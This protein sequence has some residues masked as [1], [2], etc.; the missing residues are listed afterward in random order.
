MTL[1]HVLLAGVVVAGL[2]ISGVGVASAL[3]D[4]PQDATPAPA[5]P[6]GDLLRDTGRTPLQPTQP[7]TPPANGGQSPATNPA[8]PIP[9]VGI[10]S[11][12]VTSAAEAPVDSSESA[13][14]IAR[15][16]SSAA[17]SSGTLPI[18]LR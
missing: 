5:D 9:T 15:S 4:L 10:R 16:T 2:A 18:C 13:M 7:Q 6:I 1:R 14:R 11:A 3:M 8:A 17:S 12:A